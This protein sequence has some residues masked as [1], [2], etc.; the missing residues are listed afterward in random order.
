[1]TPPLPTARIK[2]ELYASTLLSVVVTPDVRA[3]QVV[4]LP[5]LLTIVPA[6][7]TATQKSVLTQSR[8]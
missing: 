4:L 6:S 2:D 5:L 1:M 7:P 3:V 8:P